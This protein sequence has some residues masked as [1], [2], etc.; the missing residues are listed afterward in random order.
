MCFGAVYDTH[1]TSHDLVGSEADVEVVF[2]IG[3]SDVNDVA[4]S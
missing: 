4:V 3:V 1:V 2:A